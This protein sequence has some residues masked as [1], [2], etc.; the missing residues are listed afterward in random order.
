MKFEAVIGL[1]VHAQLKTKSKIFC[2][3]STQ[4]GAEPNTQ[5]CPVCIGMPGVLPV[6]NKTAIEH[7][8]KTSLALNCRVNPMSRFARKQY[9]YPDLPK[10]YQISQYE[11]PVSEHGFIDTEVE[12]NKKRIGITRIH[13]EEDAGKLLHEVG[14]RQIDGSYVDLNRTGVPLMEIVSEPDMRTPQEAYAYLTALKSV[15][16]YIDASD[17]NM[18]EGSLRCDANVSIRPVGQIEFG[19]RAE[20]KNMNSFKAVQKALEYEI[21]RQIK[22]TEEGARIVQ[23]TRLWDADKEMTFSMR[24]KEEAHDYRYFPEPDLVPVIVDEKWLVEIR[25][26]LPELSAQKKERF[27]KEYGLPEYDAGVL[28]ADRAVS[29]YFENTVKGYT[30][31]KAASNWIMVELMAQLNAANKTINE[32]LITPKHLREM[33]E[34][35]DKGTISGKIAK[36]VFEEM[37]VSGKMPDVV[38]KEKGLVQISDEGSIAKVIEEVLTANAKSVEEYKAGKTAAMNFLLGQVMKKTQGKANPGVVNKILK[39]KLG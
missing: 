8:I 7:I 10:N 36:T 3:C 1:E 13:L 15:L 37:F 27:I 11:Q 30:N 34:L 6:L 19:T 9:F 14:S 2:G 5:T 29:E 16:E 35:I 33:L 18:E 20:V 31:P 25:K 26:T 32:S 21:D 38:V 23:E 17:C 22:A 4:F 39:E 24:S 12:G 28:T